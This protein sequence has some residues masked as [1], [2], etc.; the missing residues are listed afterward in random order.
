MKDIFIAGP[1]RTAVGKFGGSLKDT[2][3]T[4]L[5]AV[6]VKETIK[7]TGL[8]PEQVEWLVMGHVTQV[9]GEG[10]NPGRIAALKAGLPIHV[11]AQSVNLNCGSGLMALF[12]AASIMQSGGADVAVAA[13]MENMSQSPYVSF[14]SRWG[15]RLG[16]LDLTDSI[17]NVLSDPLG[18]CTMDMTAENVAAK[19]GITREQQDEWACMSQNRAEAAIKAGRFKEEIVPV[20]VMQRRKEVVFDT[21]E[22]PT[23]GTTMESLAAMRPAFRKEGTVTAGNASGINDAAAALTLLTEAKAKECNVEPWARIVSWAV[24]GVEP[25]LMG[26][27]P[28]PTTQKALARAGMK[29]SDIDLIECNE[30]FAAQVVGVERELK[31]NRDIVNVNGS[32][33]SIGHPIGATGIRI[34]VTLLHEMQRRKA[35]YG[36]AT[37]CIGGGQGASV[38]VENLRR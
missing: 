3:V 25:K 6:A 18:G 11:P 12:D 10:G 33:I 9:C 30:A 5:G 35:R 2:H 21:D 7:R 16:H 38:I 34:V 8:T 23:F 20:T 19:H 27:G 36:L 15:I 14:K 24:V 22:H 31:W 17:L 13:G 29:L 32:G 28:V 26:L 4:D 1:V 37:L